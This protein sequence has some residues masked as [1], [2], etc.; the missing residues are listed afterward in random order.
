MSTKNELQEFFQK[1]RLAL[2]SYSTERIGG[3]AHMPIF[4]STVTLQDGSRFTSGE[5]STKKQAELDAA[6][7]ALEFVKKLRSVKPEPSGS[8]CVDEDN[9]VAIFVDAENTPNFTTEFV[10]NFTSQNIDIFVF[11]STSHPAGRKVK[12][13]DDGRIQIFEVPSSRNDATDI[14]IAMMVGKI[15]DDDYSY[16]NFIIV[17]NDHFADAIVDILQN[18]RIFSKINVYPFFAYV[19]RD[20]EG[21]VTTINDIITS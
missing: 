5:F 17:S 14:G 4:V 6:L 13:L 12:S 7:H 9:R 15:V 18:Y 1:A 2:P 3:A 16:R 20:L 8:L 19:C 11:Y 21:V 10:E